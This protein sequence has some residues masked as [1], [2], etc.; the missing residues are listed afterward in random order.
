LPPEIRFAK[1]GYY[2]PNKGSD[3]FN[4]GRGSGFSP[5]AA[6]DDNSTGKLPLP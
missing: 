3:K 5:E 1:V 4:V 2:N 6:A